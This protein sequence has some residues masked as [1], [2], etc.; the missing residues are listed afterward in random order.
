MSTVYARNRKRTP[1]DPVDFAAR[2][3]DLIT[4][5][6]GDERYVPKKWRLLLGQDLISKADELMD[7][8]MYA[9]GLNAK[10]EKQKLLRLIYQ[11]KAYINC[12]Q[13]DRKIARLITVV[14]TADAGGMHDIL[15][16]LGKTQTAIYNWMRAER[17]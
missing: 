12:D 10:D 3:Q 5:Q 15:E 16:M 11:R 6:C 17:G 9:N 7:N 2:L 14:P 8:V 4:K 13:L 1:F